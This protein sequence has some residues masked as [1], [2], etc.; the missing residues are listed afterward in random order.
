MLSL[1][2]PSKQ[3]TSMLPVA[4]PCLSPVSLYFLP[5]PLSG[6]RHSTL[7]KKNNLPNFLEEQAIVGDPT[8]AQRSPRLTL[9]AYAIAPA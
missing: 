7:Y 8:T 9:L 4:Y 6:L 2:S 1:V 5:W 3:P